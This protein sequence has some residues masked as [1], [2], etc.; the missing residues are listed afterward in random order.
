MAEDWFDRLSAD[1]RDSAVTLG[2]SK[3]NL[4]SDLKESFVEAGLSRR[5]LAILREA[6][7]WIVDQFPIELI[8]RSTVGGDPL[9]ART[10]LFR[11]SSSGLRSAMQAW[12][13]GVVSNN[14]SDWELYRR[15]A[16]ILI[17]AEY[18][19]LLERLTVAAATSR[20]PD[21]REVADD[22]G[23]DV[24]AEFWADNYW[25]TMRT[26]LRAGNLKS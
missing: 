7:E 17:I 11:M 5:Q 12:V 24:S 20:D 18:W 22:Y 19:D 6:P 15:T 21:I 25:K 26:S 10:V 23:G 13:D 16:E 8:T 3:S 14:S 1:A 9:A 2:I 4:V